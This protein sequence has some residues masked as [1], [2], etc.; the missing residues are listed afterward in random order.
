MKNYSPTQRCGMTAESVARHF[1]ERQGFKQITRN[2]ACRYGEIDLI[3]E[4]ATTLLFIEVRF[5]RQ[6]ILTSIESI[7]RKKQKKII[8][9]ALVFL[10]KNP[11]LKHCRFD[12]IGIDA[13]F[14][15]NAISWIKDAF[16]VK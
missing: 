2:F 9:T 13:N 6:S 4:N 16:Q 3:M 8:K 15:A 5:R 11:T 14:T 10:A 12:V 7:Q 1:L